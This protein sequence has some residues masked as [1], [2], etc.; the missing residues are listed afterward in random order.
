ME[1]PW[2][3][4]KM[5][6]WIDINFESVI[7]DKDPNEKGGSPFII[8]VKLNPHTILLNPWPELN[9]TQAAILRFLNDRNILI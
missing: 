4:S 3:S 2:Q 6:G 1:A 8:L 5:D 7:N 9:W